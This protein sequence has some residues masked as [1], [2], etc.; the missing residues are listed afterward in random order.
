ML[1]VD[2]VS[3]LGTVSTL[4]TPDT[5]KQPGQKVSELEPGTYYKQSKFGNTQLLSRF[6]NASNEHIYASFMHDAAGEPIMSKNNTYRIEEVRC[7]RAFPIPDSDKVI[8]VGDVMF[9]AKVA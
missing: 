5:A 9:K 8:E 2:T 4:N 1:R 6:D 3:T 7:V